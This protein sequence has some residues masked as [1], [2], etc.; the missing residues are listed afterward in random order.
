MVLRKWSGH[1]VPSSAE[2]GPSWLSTKR[3]IRSSSCAAYEPFVEPF[4]LNSKWL[5]L[6]SDVLQSQD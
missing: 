6:Y 5:S 2:C 3:S 4:S 1:N